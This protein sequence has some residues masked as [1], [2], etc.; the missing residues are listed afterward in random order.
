MTINLVGLQIRLNKRSQV[1]VPLNERSLKEAKNMLAE[2]D[3]DIVE[4]Q[5]DA[6]NDST[7]T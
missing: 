4:H 7:Q 2:P 5:G 3:V 1:V 6:K